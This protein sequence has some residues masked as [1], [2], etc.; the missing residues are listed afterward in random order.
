MSSRH[1]SMCFIY[2]NLFDIIS[3]PIR[4]DFNVPILKRKQRHKR[5]LY[6]PCLQLQ[7]MNQDLNSPGTTLMRP[8]CTQIVPQYAECCVLYVLHSVH[9]QPSHNFMTLWDYGPPG[10]PVHGIHQ[11]QNTGAQKLPHP[12]P[13]ELSH[14][15]Q[16]L[17]PRLI[18][19]ALAG[20]FF[21]TDATWKAHYMYY[22]IYI[23][24]MCR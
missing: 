20:G 6:K 8:V 18:F 10:P 7:L 5:M 15:R 4:R 3:N 19:P 14:T 11:E 17:N 24:S 12:P 23:T 21:T 2:V 13:G 16:G 9:E 22:L 1:C